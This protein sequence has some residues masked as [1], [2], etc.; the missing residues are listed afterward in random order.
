MAEPANIAGRAAV[1][2]ADAERRPRDAAPQVFAL[3]RRRSCDLAKGAPCR[4]QGRDHPDDRQAVCL[5]VGASTNFYSGNLLDFF[6]RRSSVQTA[7][8]FA[9]VDVFED[10]GA[11]FAKLAQQLSCAPTCCPMRIAPSWPRC[12][13]GLRPSRPRRPSRSSSAISGGRSS[14]VFE[15]F[16]PDPI[17]SASLACV[18]QARSEDRRTRG[19][20][21]AAARALAR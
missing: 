3:R 21:G 17:G 16:D 12:S 5:A 18:Y 11:S 2:P 9:C 4:V 1:A 20:E 19:G 8:E 15:T 10:I 6:L 14:D 13:I 7:R